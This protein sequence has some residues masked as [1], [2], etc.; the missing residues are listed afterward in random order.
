[1]KLI[2]NFLVTVIGVYISVGNENDINFLNPVHQFN[3]IEPRDPF[4]LIKSKIEKKTQNHRFNSEKEFL[5]FL[6]NE[7][8]IDPFSQL[9]VYSTTSL[10]LRKISIY[11]PRSIYF[12]DDIYIGFVPGGQIEVIGI[13]PKLGAIP[14]I[15]E[16]PKYGIIEQPIIHRSS[17]CMNCHASNDIGGMPGLLISSVIPGPGGGTLDRF[18]KNKIGHDIPFNVRFGG[19]HITGNN[20]FPDSWANKTGFMKNGNITKV[21][22]SPGVNFNWNKYPVQSSA[23]AAHLIFEHQAGFTNLCIQATYEFR[24][25]I[26]ENKNLSKL[27]QFI[28][29]NTNELIEYILFKNEPKIENYK[30]DRNNP[31]VRNFENKKEGN[32]ASNKF[33]KLNLK[34]RLLENRCSYMIFSKSFQ[35]LPKEIKSNVIKKLKILL[36][37]NNFTEEYSYIGIEEKKEIFGTFRDLSKDL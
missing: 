29:K 25:L 36:N 21:D 6:L 23:A 9:L 27:N 3:E 7:L 17:R 5:M 8:S 28:Q 22:N 35:G 2:F 32:L 31:F 4:S 20:P 15:F 1:M 10:Q 33:R 37:P 13:D 26:N 30:I 18:R 12:T 16:I 19:W 11:N 24:E 34:S 14:Y